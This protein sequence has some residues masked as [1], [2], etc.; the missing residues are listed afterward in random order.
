[1]INQ[2]QRKENPNVTVLMS[3]YNA[4]KYLEK[5]IDSILNQT[6]KSFEFLIIDDGSNDRTAEILKSYDDPR[7]K[8]IT[9][10][11]NIGLTKSL[12]KG[13]RRIRGEYIARMDSDDISLPD[14]LAK[15][16]YYLNTHPEVGVLGSATQI[17]DGCGNLSYIYRFPVEHGLIRWCLLF[18]NPIVHP[19]VMIRREVLDQIGGYHLHTIR[20]QD[21]DLWWRLSKVTRLGNL[22][23]VLLYLRKHKESITEKHLVQQ[24]KSS[25]KISHQIMSDMLG[26]DVPIAVLQSL[27]NQDFMS[28]K[29]VFRAASLIF[30]LYQVSVIDS[31]LST[32]EKKN[33][34]RDAAS[35]LLDLVR[36]RKHDVHMVKVLI[37]ACRVDPLF[38]FRT[39]TKDIH[40]LVKKLVLA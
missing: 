36:T 35:R 18:Y 16:V 40:K 14:R 15:Q 22:P 33:I 34:R 17:I 6:L 5:A 2:F 31:T 30:R 37:L 7:I 12:N 3:V 24:R 4:E 9:N 32:S 29:D 20:A 1:M 21:Y 25:I 28:W 38:L 10:E 11:K 19:S 39:L 23:D 26:N 8:I 13:L 27:R